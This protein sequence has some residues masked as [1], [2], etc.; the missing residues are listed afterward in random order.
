VLRLAKRAALSCWR[1]KPARV[2]CGVVD[3]D[4]LKGSGEFKTIFGRFKLRQSAR[5][6]A[7]ASRSRLCRT[8]SAN[9]TVNGSSEQRSTI[10]ILFRAALAL[11][12]SS[13]AWLVALRPA[14]AEL[15][16][17]IAI[18]DS[19]QYVRLGAEI[20][21]GAE[22]ATADINAAGG[23]LG[24]QLT[25]LFEDDGCSAATGH[26]LASEIAN[27]RPAVII[28]HPCSSAAIAAAQ[29]Y[30][31]SSLLLIATGAMHPRL[32]DARAGATIFRLAAREDRQAE[33]AGRFMA[34][35]FNGAKTAVL[36]DRSLLAHALAQAVDA[37]L[38]KNGK[39]D[40]LIE[41][42][43]TGSM[44]YTA[45]I[46]SMRN[47]HAETIYVAGY[48]TEAALILRQMRE[49][50][51][52]AKFIGSDVLT[53]AD[54]LAVAKGAAEGTFVTMIPP[55][56][57]FPAAAPV[58]QR[59][60]AKKGIEGDLSALLAYAALQTWSEAARTAGSLEPIKTTAVLTAIT[61]DT[62]LGAL[63]F[64]A[65]GDSNLPAYR[66]HEMHDGAWLPR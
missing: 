44:D 46:E 3:A 11:A 56:G 23:V 29:V 52:A 63:A 62:V 24:N 6:H 40:T 35:N 60:R 37:A 13:A 19:G 21:A 53:A 64:D 41:S 9:E 28:G 4:A 38:K 59:L 49:L 15:A 54:F 57:S 22:L 48:P 31:K 58:L 36:H 45:L 18:P 43:M 12:A 2:H 26:Q 16:I 10:A 55:P 8:G 39:V 25:L 7:L 47:K 34:A 20:R 30:A 61:V 51:L 42:F 32:T 33:S 5:R 1:S 27:K 65:H 17:A 50:G 14:T 66:V